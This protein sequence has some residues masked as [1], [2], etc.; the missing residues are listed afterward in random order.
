MKGADKESTQVR[1]LVFLSFVMTFY[2]PALCPTCFFSSVK[3]VKFLFFVELYPLWQSK[4][5]TQNFKWTSFMRQNTT[6]LT[7]N[8]FSEII[9]TRENARKEQN[10][11]DT[12]KTETPNW[13]YLF[14]W[15][16]FISIFVLSGMKSLPSVH[17]FFLASVKL[18]QG[19]AP[20]DGFSL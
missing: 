11:Q 20:F 17:F 15:I 12:L 3:N 7:Q 9:C 19:F 1:L 18:P 8:Y 10:S 13:C 14:N 2:K 4:D 5:L 6:V 16:S